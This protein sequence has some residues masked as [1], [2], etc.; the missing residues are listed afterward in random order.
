MNFA[1]YSVGI[2]SHSSWQC[3][4]KSSKVF[5]LLGSDTPFQCVRQVFDRIEIGTLWRPIQYL[6]FVVS[7]PLFDNVCH[8]LGIVVLLKDPFATK[9]SF[10]YLAEDLRLCFNISIYCSFRIIPST[11]L[12]F[13][14]PAAAKHPHH[15]ILSPLCFTVGMVL[16][17]WNASPSFRQT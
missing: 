11:L 15:M 6:Y 16:F 9:W 3:W 1:Q 13:P 4:Y 14:V 12:S 7:K 2:F 8:M 10:N 5:G 17:E